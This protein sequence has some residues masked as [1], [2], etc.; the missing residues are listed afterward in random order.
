MVVGGLRVLNG[1]L[2]VGDLLVFVSY[3][4]SLHSIDAPL[5]CVMVPTLFGVR[6]QPDVARQRGY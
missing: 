4:A 2:T 3:L 1:R 6:I 5:R